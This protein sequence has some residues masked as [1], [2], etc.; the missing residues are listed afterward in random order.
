M[1]RLK[2]GN[3]GI[4]NATTDL[5]TPHCFGM[6]ELPSALIERA[7]V[8][9]LL[10]EKENNHLSEESTFLASPLYV[11]LSHG[12]AYTVGSALGSTPPI[13]NTCFAAYLVPNIV[14][15][16][17]GAR[18]W[19]KYSHRSMPKSLEGDQV[20]EG[21]RKASDGWWG[22]P[23]GPVAVINDKA[24][25]IFWKV[26]STATWKNLHWLPHKVLVYEVRVAEGYGMRW[27]QDQ[28][29]VDGQTGLT[30]LRYDRP[31]MFRGF[32]EPMMENGHEL[33]WRHAVDPV[34]SLSI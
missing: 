13:T 28:R 2:S 31:W 10:R 16:T 18:A 24:L 12:L 22:T 4:E 8:S 3:V 15:L 26:M 25:E 32:V 14:G 27:S 19:T 1:D 29:N 6:S 30:G 17:A 20:E 23:C 34:P 21:K 7:E 9:R 11:H 5:F 33:G